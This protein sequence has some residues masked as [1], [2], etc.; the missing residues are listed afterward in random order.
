MLL[1]RAKRHRERRL[2]RG[3]DARGRPSQ[4]RRAAQA[5]ERGEALLLQLYSNAA[6]T[7]G[8]SDSTV[9]G[10]RNITDPSPPLIAKSTH[11]AGTI[12]GSGLDN[13]I[14]TWSTCGGVR[15]GATRVRLRV[16]TRRGHLP[17]GTAAQK[18]AF[19]DS[20]RRKGAIPSSV[21]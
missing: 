17:C 18:N 4:Q 14:I 5:L 9:L 8:L 2:E 19:N 1:Q 12:D 6:V 3:R 10:G 16:T 15:Q 13:L 20:V 21:R 11:F 7:I